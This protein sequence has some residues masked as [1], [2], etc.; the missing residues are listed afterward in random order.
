MNEI[1]N[2]VLLAE[3]KYMPG[4]YLRQPEFTYSTCGP[5]TKNKKEIKKYNEAVD[6][7]YIYQNELD[8]AYFRHDM[9]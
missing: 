7:K 6:L 9:A 5:F 1:V 3:D 2:M 8:K 4:M